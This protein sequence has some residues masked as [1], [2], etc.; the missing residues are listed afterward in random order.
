MR[1]GK[2]G[3]AMCY[4]KYLKVVRNKVPAN[5]LMIPSGLHE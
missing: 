4:Y 2:G 5:D 1:G 3:N